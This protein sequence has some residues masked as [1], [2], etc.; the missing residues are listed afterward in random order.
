[1]SGVSGRPLSGASGPPRG[2]TVLDAIPPAAGDVV[3]ASAILCVDLRL[4]GQP[5][6][7]AVP[8]CFAAATRLAVTVG[9][10]VLAGLVRR[11]W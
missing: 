3:M 7:A 8:L 9:L 10:L 1:L 5:V 2:R 4:V 6:A 11:T